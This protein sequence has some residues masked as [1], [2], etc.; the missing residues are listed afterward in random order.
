MMDRFA[1]LHWPSIIHVRGGALRWLPLCFWLVDPQH[2]KQIVLF[3]GHD[4]DSFGIGTNL[5]SRVA[6]VA[7]A[8]L[9]VCAGAHNLLFCCWS[10]YRC[11]PHL[12]VW[13]AA[14]NSSVLLMRR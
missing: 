5:V 10:A 14:Q 12:T 8:C 9:C 13:R 4:V 2:R 1:V 7:A 11:C 6:A 3:A